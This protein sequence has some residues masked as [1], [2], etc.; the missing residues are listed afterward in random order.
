MVAATQKA[1]SNVDPALL[2][3]GGLG[4]QACWSSVCVWAPVQ[5]SSTLATGYRGEERWAGCVCSP[6][7]QVGR[8]HSE[9]EG[10]EGSRWSRAPGSLPAVTR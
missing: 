1:N 8:L 7:R 10:G 3:Y 9:V 6:W 5:T 2:W 4:G